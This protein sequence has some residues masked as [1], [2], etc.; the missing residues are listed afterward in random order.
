M[1]LEAFEKKFNFD[2]E[3]NN[4]Q[5]QDLSETFLN[6]KKDVLTSLKQNQEKQSEL[7]VTVQE[8]IK[9]MI[10]ERNEKNDFLNQRIT[11]LEKQVLSL[12][13]EPP[14]GQAKDKKF[15]SDQLEQLQSDFKNFR[16]ETRKSM[17]LTE[18][19]FKTRLQ[20]L[21]NNLTNLERTVDLS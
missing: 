20:S 10:E 6:F 9:F 14:T 7:G 12:Q 15:V 1:K 16:N 17:C 4:Q 3:V 13:A 5:Y 21:Q 19:G 11:F 18:K 8:F 2:T